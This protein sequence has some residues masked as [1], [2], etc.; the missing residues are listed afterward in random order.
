MTEGPCGPDHPGPEVEVACE[1][2]AIV[3]LQKMHEVVEDVM[4]SDYLLP[5]GDK[6]AAR[7][8]L[9]DKVYGPDCHRIL[10]ASSVSAGMRVADLGC[11]T[12][13]TTVWFAAQVGSEGEVCAVDFSPDQL[14]V[15]RAHGCIVK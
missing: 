7:L 14:A 10:A 12:G 4:T 15:A 11:G 2:I 8:A 9:V 3:Y 6:G 1:A 5:T 13:S